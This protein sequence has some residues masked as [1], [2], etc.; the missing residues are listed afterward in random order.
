M[1]LED[2]ET[3]DALIRFDTHDGLYLIHCHQPAHEDSGMM[4]NF[5]VV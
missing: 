4:M 2:K 5:E 1:L 3:V